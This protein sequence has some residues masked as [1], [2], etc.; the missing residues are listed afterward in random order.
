[1]TPSIVAFIELTQGHLAIVD[2]DDYEELSKFKWSVM[3]KSNTFYAKRGQPGRTAA[4][5]MHRQI[6]KAVD[7]VLVDHVN[8]NGLDNRKCNLRFCT[9]QQNA[10]NTKRFPNKKSS[11]FKGV[12]KRDNRWQVNICFGG[13]LKYVGFFRTEVEAAI[14]YNEAAK[15]YHGE[16]ARLNEV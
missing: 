14:A 12:Y 10:F 3:D 11:R 1:M 16:F 4:M 2:A 8:G 6:M 7:G 13:K 15:K 5:L 9:P